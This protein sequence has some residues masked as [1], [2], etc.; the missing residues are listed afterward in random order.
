MEME[1]SS[2]MKKAS[3]SVSN[4]WFPP[5]LA[6]LCILITLIGLYLLESTLSSGTPGGISMWVA[7]ILILLGVVGAVIGF[8]ILRG[9]GNKSDSANSQVVSMGTSLAEVDTP[10]LASALSALTT[11][12]LTRR[13][14]I[15]TREL[16]LGNTGSRNHT[17][18]KSMNAILTSLRECTR[19]YNWITDEPC[20]RLFYKGTDSFQEGL[21]AGEAMGKIVNDRAKILLSSALHQDNLKLRIN[22][23][24]TSLTANFPG[25]KVVRILD[26]SGLTEEQIIMEIESVMKENPDLAG[27]YGTDIESFMPM[28]H[29][30]KKNQL[31]G[32]IKVV[33]HD[34]SDDI[35][36]LIQE[37]LITESVC[38]NPFAQGYDTAIHLYNHLVSGW[39]PPVERL[40]ITPDI[41]NREN[42]DKFWKIGQGAFQ[43]EEAIANRPAVMPN[44]KNK[45]IKIAMVGADFTF[46]DDVRDGVQ[47]ASKELK[48]FNA[49]ADWLLPPGTRTDHGISVSSEIYSPFLEKLAADGYDAIGV[50]VGDSEISKT[51]NKLVEKGIPIATFNAETSSMRGL[52]LLLVDRARQVLEASQM[53]ND[54][55]QNATHATDSV[56]GTITQ[57]TK[58]VTDEAAMMSRANG[59]VQTIVDNIQQISR[60]A[61]EQ[62]QAAESAV[63]AS[64]Q[65]AKAVEQTSEAIAN[66]TVT[67]DNSFKVAREG[68]SSV[69]QALDQMGSIQQAVETSASSIQMM[70]TYSNQIGEIVETIRDIADQTN[71]LALNAAIEAAR[72]GEQGRGFAVVAGEVRKLAEKSGE[73][74]REIATIVQNT[75]KNIS[76]TVKS[77]QTA[78]DRVSE[79]SSL[80][81]SSGQALELLVTSAA[82]MQTQTAGASK[83]NAA[84]VDV[85]EALNT[86]IERVS[87][88]I[89]QNSASS[90]EI[91]QNAADT[92][93]IMESVAA[94]SEENA[95]SS[96]EIAA[97]TMEVN[98]KVSQ[99]AKEVEKLEMLAHEMQASTANFKL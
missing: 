62:S 23:F 39:N 44:S 96:Q 68:A 3:I 79:G 89:E 67:A 21:S 61:M 14:Q 35:A 78:I 84:M 71:L 82:E 56:A 41:V 53:L 28:L 52:M 75:Q 59:S 97:S 27:F 70:A 73:A 45:P 31:Q 91:T 64:M 74:T 22:G 17:L 16:D 57:I 99:M 69:R 46:F 36:R 66:V 81:A 85:M 20:K 12:D 13:A 80:A 86:S 77:M 58:S 26:S 18:Q 93:D 15:T 38:Q 48:A 34:L 30:M 76:E 25:V 92:L 65:I 2:V 29:F 42:L 94:F 50:M 90:T 37:G 54:L 6:V 9:A 11:G 95:A 49:K 83:A 51:I 40:L 55:A 32:K 98:D 63:T 33:C 5:V 8:L 60:G 19:S 87:A 88:V 4:R 47:I 43:S 7:R 1:R 10:G 72:A 24:N